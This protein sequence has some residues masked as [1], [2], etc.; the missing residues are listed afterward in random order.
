MSD[1]LFTSKRLGFR[2]WKDSDL[3]EMSQINLDKE[4]QEN[5]AHHHW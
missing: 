1:Y 5:T 3:A 2:N 4:V